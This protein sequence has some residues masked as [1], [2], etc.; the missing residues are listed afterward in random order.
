M[1]VVIYH[2]YRRKTA[3]SDTTARF[4]VKFASSVQ[5]SHMYPKLL[6]Q[7]IH[8]LAGTPDITCSAKARVDTEPS[9]WLE[10]KLGIERYYPY[11]SDS[12]IPDLDIFF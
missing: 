8:Y 4:R 3:R 9:F 5:I 1:N 6:L 10:I 7:L 11:I 12:G 2:Y